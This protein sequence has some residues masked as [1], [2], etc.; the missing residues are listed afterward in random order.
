LL[1]LQSTDTAKTCS[2]VTLA[3]TPSGNEALDTK[4]DKIVTYPCLS[5]NMVRS[6]LLPGGHA[7]PGS[8]H[9]TINLTAEMLS[10]HTRHVFEGRFTPLRLI[11][12]GRKGRRVVVVLGSDRKHYRVLDL[13]FSE[14]IKREGEEDG[15]SSEEDSDVEM[16]GA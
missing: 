4:S 8:A 3:Y 1:L 15:E 10:K 16:G 13:D 7:L 5:S 6:T 12:N 2:I 14:K 11:V 9:H